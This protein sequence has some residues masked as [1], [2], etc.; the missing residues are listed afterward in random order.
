MKVGFKGLP[1]IIIFYLYTLWSFLRFEIYISQR[2]TIKVAL[3]I[4]PWTFEL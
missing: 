1:G 2:L 4:I 3:I